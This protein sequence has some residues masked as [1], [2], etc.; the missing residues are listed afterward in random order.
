M[1]NTNQARHL[2]TVLTLQTAAAYAHAAAVRAGKVRVAGQQS[3][4]EPN[5]ACSTH[6][7]LSPATPR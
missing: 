3:A 1:T 7:H 5:R 4:D 6:Y 2:Q